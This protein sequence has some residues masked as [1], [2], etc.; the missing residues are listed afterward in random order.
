MANTNGQQARDFLQA[1]LSEARHKIARLEHA[2]R[3]SEDPAEVTGL[4]A[5]IRAASAECSVIED[6]LAH[7]SNPDGAPGLS[8]QVMARLRRLENHSDHAAMRWR[9]GQPTPSTYWETTQTRTILEQLLR[10]W[11]AWQAGRPYYPVVANGTGNGAAPPGR[12]IVAPDRANPWSLPSRPTGPAEPAAHDD[13]EKLLERNEA[14]RADLL[15]A[16]ARAGVAPD[17]VEIIF[18]SDHM[19]VV[20]AYAHSE[21]ERRAIVNTVLGIEEIDTVLAD[22]R[23]MD[24]A[25]CPACRAR[26]ETPPRPQN[27]SAP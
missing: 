10:R 25:R 27:N 18:A 9:R 7:L 4:D 17:H 14:R 21:A 13:P 15:A 11:H 16:L 20:T 5:M 24:P 19:A 1:Q 26:R 12:T 8:A 2:R 22:I 23:V 6:L 3:H